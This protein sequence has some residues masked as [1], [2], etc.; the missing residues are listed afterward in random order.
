[1]LVAAT[2]LPQKVRQYWVIRAL[3]AMKISTIWD[4]DLLQVRSGGYR[5]KFQLIA[6]MSLSH[7]QKKR[8]ELTTTE[9]TPKLPQIYY[10]YYT[11]LL[12]ARKW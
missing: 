4:V 8:G 5:K 9:K 6:L 1:V 10:F 7:P 11:Y 3:A 12:I 2:L